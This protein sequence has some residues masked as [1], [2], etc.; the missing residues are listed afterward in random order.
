MPVIGP[1]QRVRQR[2]VFPEE[3]S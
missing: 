1:L 3:L 2:S